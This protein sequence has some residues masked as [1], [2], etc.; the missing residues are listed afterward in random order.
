MGIRDR[1]DSHRDTLVLGISHIT[2]R[3]EGNFFFF[4]FDDSSFL[5]LQDNNAFFSLDL[6]GLRSL[7]RH[8]ILGSILLISLKCVCSQP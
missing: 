5:Q 7:L 6:L 3:W 2:P 4:F 8:F 1:T